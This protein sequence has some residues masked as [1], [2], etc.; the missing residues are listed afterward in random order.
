MFYWYDIET[1]LMTT[2]TC[3]WFYYNFIDFIKRHYIE[4]ASCEFLDL[5]YMDWHQYQ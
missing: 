1:S 3:I 2:F 4:I 5:E